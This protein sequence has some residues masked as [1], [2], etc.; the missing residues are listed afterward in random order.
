M[1][2]VPFSL[3]IFGGLGRC[4]GILRDE[5]SYLAV[6]FQNA[7]ALAG[8]IKSDVK[9]IRVA[10]RDLQSVTLTKGWLGMGFAG[11]KIILNAG[12]METLK[13]IP[14]MVQGKVALSISRKN[15]EAAEQLVAGLHQ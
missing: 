15:R 6:E 9:V 12:K 3:D 8:I 7:D 2:S 4:E 11:V 14:G 10:L 13:D 5:G 1:N